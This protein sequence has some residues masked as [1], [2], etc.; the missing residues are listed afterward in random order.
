M[1]GFKTMGLTFVVA[2]GV[3]GSAREL[4]RPTRT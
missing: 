2:L 4:R 3:S 1:R